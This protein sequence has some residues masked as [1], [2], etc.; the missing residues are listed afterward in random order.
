MTHHWQREVNMMVIMTMRVWPL[1]INV[2]WSV[3]TSRR[4]HYGRLQPTQ[5]PL[6]GDFLQ[7]LTAMHCQLYPHSNLE[8]R[9]WII[10]F[11]NRPYFQI[12][13]GSGKPKHSSQS[14][15][16][17]VDNEGKVSE[18]S[19]RLVVSRSLGIPEESARPL[20][21]LPL[22]HLT[23][24]QDDHH[25]GLLTM[26]I[27]LTMR[28]MMTMRLLKIEN[29]IIMIVTMIV[30]NIIIHNKPYGTI[31]ASPLSISC[32]LSGPYW[33]HLTDCCSYHSGGNHVHL[34]SL[35]CYL[36]SI[37]ILTYLLPF[38]LFQK[39]L[40][41]FPAFKLPVHCCIVGGHAH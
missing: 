36:P 2:F 20:G 32:H 35:V 33:Q 4:L 29:F 5:N 41:P 38:F 28:I 9:I 12:W 11:I 18:K 6:R 14:P 37:H 1:A 8:K 19:G 26:T 7:T 16:I 34:Y 40:L 39:L 23:S 25:P 30:T 22:H 15:Q 3:I 31:D 27:I 24:P 21:L 13:S 17:I 10:L